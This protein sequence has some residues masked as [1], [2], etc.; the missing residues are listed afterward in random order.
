M[1]DPNILSDGET[2]ETEEWITHSN[3]LLA[4]LHRLVGLA[5]LG[6]LLIVGAVYAWPHLVE[7]NTR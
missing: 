3:A 2:R 6:A 5:L 4:T 1:S 7:L